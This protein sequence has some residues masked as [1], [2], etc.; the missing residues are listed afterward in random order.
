MSGR[1]FSGSADT[2]TINAF[3]SSATDRLADAVRTATRSWSAAPGG[4]TPSLAFASFVSA[5]S[6]PAKGAGAP[7][8]FV[9]DL[10]SDIGTAAWWRG[11]GSLTA[12]TAV[13]GWVA[14]SPVR[15]P[16]YA[17]PA[18]DAQQFAALD[19]VSIAPLAEGGHMGPAA[20]PTALSP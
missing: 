14:L 12:M 10:G 9:V 2:V 5:G 17:A 8:G 11:L 7:K 6:A 16:A 13:L 19:S 3:L 15:L 18:L 20:A 1:K 4:K